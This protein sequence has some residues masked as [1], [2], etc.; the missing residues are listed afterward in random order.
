MLQFEIDHSLACC[1]SLFVFCETVLI[2][3]LLLVLKFNFIIYRLVYTYI[4]Y[5]LHKIYTIFFVAVLSS[6]I[7]A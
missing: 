3:N 5:T 2:S 6:E 4:F 1:C 7:F